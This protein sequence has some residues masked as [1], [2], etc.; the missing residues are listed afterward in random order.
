MGYMYVIADL[1]GDEPIVFNNHKNILTNLHL[2]LPSQTHILE[3]S[4]IP[5]KQ[6]PIKIKLSLYSNINR[7]QRKL[8]KIGK[9]TTLLSP[10]KVPIRRRTRR[11]GEGKKG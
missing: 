8:K 11:E 3:H 4:C 6:K 10:A 9:G 7:N 5:T 1:H 2:T